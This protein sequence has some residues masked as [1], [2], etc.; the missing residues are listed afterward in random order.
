MPFCKLLSIGQISSSAFQF[1][2]NDHVPSKFSLSSSNY[3]HFTYSFFFSFITT[4]ARSDTRS[5]GQNDEQRSPLQWVYSLAL[6][7]PAAGAVSLECGK[8]NYS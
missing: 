7:T 1:E 5:Q 6:E 2:V 3:K 8:Y 4:H